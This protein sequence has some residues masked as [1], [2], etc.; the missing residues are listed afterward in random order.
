MEQ[1]RTEPRPLGKGPHSFTVPDSFFEPMPD[2]SIPLRIAGHDNLD[3]NPEDGGSVV[4]VAGSDVLQ[5]AWIAVD[6]RA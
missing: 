2:D 1:K 3:S 6:K 4:I 5:Q